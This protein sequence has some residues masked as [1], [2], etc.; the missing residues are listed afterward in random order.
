MAYGREQ[1]HAYRVVEDGWMD[2]ECIT[3]SDGA[4]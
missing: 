1:W 3:M 4:L 2:G